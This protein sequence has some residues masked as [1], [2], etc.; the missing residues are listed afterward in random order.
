M[1]IDGSG[2]KFAFN[3]FFVARVDARALLE[4]VI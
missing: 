4:V 3:L 2:G 1:V